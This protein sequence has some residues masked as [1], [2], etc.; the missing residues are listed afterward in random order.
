MQNG[1]L[2]IKAGIVWGFFSLQ[3]SGPVT[4]PGRST[5]S[6]GCYWSLA[7]IER[8]RAHHRRGGVALKNR[9]PGPI[10]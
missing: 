7:G 6:P 1:K 5:R 10:F 8:S 3:Q 2:F 9:I 4:R